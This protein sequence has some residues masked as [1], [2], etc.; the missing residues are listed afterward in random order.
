MLSD[1]R[2]CFVGDSFVAG[3]G[4]PDHLGWTG[5]VAARTHR[6][7]RPLT[8]YN[9]G[10]RRNTSDDVLG[11]WRAECLP[12]FPD[13]CTGAIALSFGVNDTMVENGGRRVPADRSAANLATLLG[14][15]SSATGPVLVI[16]PVP[17]ADEAHNQRTADL[18]ET[19]RHVCAVRE[20]SYVDVFEPL[21]ASAAWRRDVEAGDG[22]HPADTGYAVLA[23]L[24]W[25]RWSAW[26]SESL[27]G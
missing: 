6:S 27:A 15:M 26:V 21:L 11:R 23:D 22:A 1:L 16:G 14:E 7:G 12:R 3:V 24:V 18:N 25:P 2:V 19:F 13:G 5:R 17:V 4:D 8:T 9:L 20:V 10:I